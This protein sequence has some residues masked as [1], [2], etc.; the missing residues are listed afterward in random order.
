MKNVLPFLVAASP[1]VLIFACMRSVSHARRSTERE[2]E[3]LIAEMDEVLAPTTPLPGSNRRPA[4]RSGRERDIGDK[5]CESTPIE[6][7][8]IETFD[9]EGGVNTS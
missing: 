9:S 7:R 2:V 6:R 1:G 4:E 5:G 8:P 3:R